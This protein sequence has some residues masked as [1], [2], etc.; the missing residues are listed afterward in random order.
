MKEF[1]TLAFIGDIMLGRGVNQEIPYRSPESFWGN[2][3]PV[4]QGADAAIANL[5]CAITQHTGKCSR[6]PKVF[7]F[8]ADPAAVEVLRT[9][10]IQCVSLAN[11]HILDFDDRGLLDTLDY[12][13]A[14]GILHAGAG[15]NLDE[16]T[17]PAVIDISGFKV[18]VIALTDNEPSFAAGGDRPGTY[19]L[20]IPSAPNTLAL[21]EKSVKQLQ[22]AGVGL[23]VLSAHWGPNM[24]TSPPPHFRKFARAVVDCGVDLF[25]GHSAHLFQG[26]ECCGHSLILYDT[27]D[28]LDDYTVDPVLRNDWS[29]VFLL[30]VDANGLRQLRMLPVRLEY[31]RVELAKGEEFA[32]IRKRMQSLCAAFDTPVLEIPEGLAIQLQQKCGKEP[33]LE[34]RSCQM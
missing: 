19:Y 22:Q 6:T 23:V 27:G 12:L 2:V 3:L 29:F 32:A 24:V 11:N 33:M 18:G 13:D 17:T 15:R 7:Y 8:R 25:Y 20:K 28:F 26:V 1:V 34:P 21:I 4:L 30:E 14:A 16:A 31:A 10:N 5:E 9:A